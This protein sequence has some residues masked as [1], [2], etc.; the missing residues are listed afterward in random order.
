MMIETYA[1]VFRNLLWLFFTNPL[2]ADPVASSLLPPRVSLTM[3]LE[4]RLSS[5]VAQLYNLHTGKSERD[6]RK[7]VWR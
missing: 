4:P 2:S 3:Y 6:V 5:D 7:S 1:D